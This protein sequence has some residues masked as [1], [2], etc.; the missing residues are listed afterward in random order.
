MKNKNFHIS[1]KV[2]SVIT[3]SFPYA[4]PTQIDQNLRILGPTL[5]DEKVSTLLACRLKK[6]ISYI[7]QAVFFVKNTIIKYV[8]YITV[9]MRR[10]IV[11][12]ISAKKRQE[13]LVRLL[14]SNYFGRFRRGKNRSPVWE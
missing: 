2:R 10:W 12:S 13:I 3:L 9:Y 7:N 8:L 4:E 5:K 11:K 6:N 14:K 1:C